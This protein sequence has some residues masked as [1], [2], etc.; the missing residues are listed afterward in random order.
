MLTLTYGLKK[1]EDDDR[2]QIVFDALEGNIT[3]LDPHDHDGVTSKLIPSS[4]IVPVTVTIA[5]ASWALVADGIYKQTITLPTAFAYD[6]TT[7]SFH[8]TSSGHKVELEV[9]KVS[10]SQFDVYINDNTL[11]VKALYN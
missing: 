10:S 8:L 3:Q 6:T 2:G 7:F 1:P 5:N 11:D 4:S 9:E